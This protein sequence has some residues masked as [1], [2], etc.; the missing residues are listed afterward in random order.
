MK[1]VRENLLF[2]YTKVRIIIIGMRT[3]V[4]DPI[5]IQVQIVEFRDLMLFNDFTQ[6]WI[7]LTEPA[8]KFWYSHI[9]KLGSK[10]SIAKCFVRSKFKNKIF[11]RKTSCFVYVTM[12]HRIFKFND[13]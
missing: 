2:G 6:T 3:I 11:F 5:H 1:N 8:V 7:S 13:E 9:A 4:N 10:F 12:K